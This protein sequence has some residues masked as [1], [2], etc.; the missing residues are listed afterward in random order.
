MASNPPDRE[1]VEKKDNC[2]KTYMDDALLLELNRLA[3]EDDRKL[4]D[5]IE[6]VLR[7][8]VW[9]HGRRSPPRPEGPS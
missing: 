6:R 9:G 7:C 4:S 8:H 5:Y 2:V 1:R 3:A